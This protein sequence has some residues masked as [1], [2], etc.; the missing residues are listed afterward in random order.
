[1][2]GLMALQMPCVLFLASGEDVTY[3]SWNKRN[4]VPGLGAGSL[5]RLPGLP[6]ANRHLMGRILRDVRDKWE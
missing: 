4:I 1:M 3:E 2:Y 6:Q 5:T